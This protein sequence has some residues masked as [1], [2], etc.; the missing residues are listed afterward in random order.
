MSSPAGLSMRPDSS[1]GCLMRAELRYFLLRAV[2]RSL[3]AGVPDPLD[4]AVVEC[5]PL[6][7]TLRETGRESA[8]RRGLLLSSLIFSYIGSHGSGTHGLLGWITHGLNGRVA[9]GWFSLARKITHGLLT[10]RF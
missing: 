4:G 5:D 1:T 9:H 7:Q 10:R 2:G 6:R 8:R 3:L